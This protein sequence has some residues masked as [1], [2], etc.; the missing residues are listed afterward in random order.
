MNELLL[1][2]LQSEEKDLMLSAVLLEEYIFASSGISYACI[3]EIIKECLTAIQDIDE[4]LEQVEQLINELFV[5]HLLLDE[6]RDFWPLT[7]YQLQSGF[8]YRTL[9]PSLKVMVIYYIITECGFDVD[10]IFVPEKNMIRVV[11]DDIYAIIFD[12]VTGESLN[13]HELD[14]RM[15]E[16][17]GDPSE[18]NLS[19]IAHND[20]LIAHITSLKNA[21]IREHSF[22]LALK[23]VSILLALRPDDPF[24]RRDRGFLLQQ[25]DCFKVAYDD[26]R[27]FVEQ[28][29]K[30]PA[31]QLLKI[32]LDN[33]SISDT[34]I[35]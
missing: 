35:H 34:V 10:I 6:Y 24:E 13:W 23:C 26:Y 31:A 8:D 17:D 14:K 22:D 12:P 18:H 11:C 4:P 15:D 21:L 33:I 3:D 20:I 28:C 5:H 9:A 7:S 1:S 19:P 32:Q 27:F 25:L 29:P 2:E 30:D 16:L